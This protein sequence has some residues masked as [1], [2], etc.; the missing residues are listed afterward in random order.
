MQEQIEAKCEE[1]EAKEAEVEASDATVEETRKEQSELN[2]KFEELRSKRSELEDVRYD[3][4]TER[5]SLKTLKME[6]RE[7]ETERDDLPDVPAG[8]IEELDAELQH[9]RQQKQQL[10]AEVADLRSVIEFNEEQPDDTESG[11]FLELAETDTTGEAEI[12][13][14]QPLADS[15]DE[16]TYWM[17]GSTVNSDQI[18]TTVGRLRELSQQKVGDINELEDKIDD[19][20]AD[21]RELE[22]A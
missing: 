11:P 16:V 5:E 6:H 21:K 18:E 2:D 4:E 15:N 12:V 17:C 8:E 20:E 1:L 3:L 19:P 22:Q 9:L 10:E 14:N 13:T 7:L